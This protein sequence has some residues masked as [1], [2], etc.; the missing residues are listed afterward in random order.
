MH[1]SA[2]KAVGGDI[3]FAWLR[4]SRIGGDIWDNSDV[5]L[6]EESEAYEVDIVDAGTVR[7]TLAASTPQ[8]LYTSAQQTADFGAPQA[9]YTIRITQLSA[10][11]GRGAPKE[12]TLNV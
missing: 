7:R 10:A 4:R 3:T 1:V 8:A 5:P 6:S 2:A 9:A 12:V 11:F